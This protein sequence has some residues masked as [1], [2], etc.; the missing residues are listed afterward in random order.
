MKTFV[1]I[2]NNFWKKVPGWCAFSQ[3]YME[4]V[5]AAPKDRES[6]FVEVGSWLGR[7]AALMG[8]E[9]HNSR[10]PIRLICIDPWADG[11][12]D[13]RD[14]RYFKDLKQSP[15]D[16]FCAN[17]QPVK[18]YLLPLRMPSFEAVEHIADQ[19]IDFLMLDGDHSYETVKKEIQLYLPKMKD[20]GVISGDDYTWPGVKQAVDE[21]FPGV[22]EV[23]IIN[24]N[25]DWRK[26][27]SY[28]KVQL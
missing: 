26:D 1:P 7:S 20:G 13:L 22:T 17:V 8:T 28:W 10:K 12:P 19:S 11:G 4:M 2:R 16:L 21:A 25:A 15:Y 27:A 23:T 24:K 9:I 3:L 14:T 6:L 5:A 18:E